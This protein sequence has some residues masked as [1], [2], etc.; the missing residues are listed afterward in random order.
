MRYSI[1]EMNNS[2][3]TYYEVIDTA[4]NCKTVFQTTNYIESLDFTRQLETN[5]EKHYAEILWSWEDVHAVRPEWDEA[6]CR[7]WWE[8]NQKWF[9]DVLTEHG[10]EMLSDILD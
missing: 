3:F 2:G 9:R 1:Q 6:K 8:N 10:N 5:G 4:D 7:E